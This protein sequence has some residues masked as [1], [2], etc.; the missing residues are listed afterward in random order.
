MVD[1][2]NEVTQN[3]IKSI[4][5]M[6]QINQIIK[7]KDIT[8]ASHYMVPSLKHEVPF[9]EI[10][11]SQQK[12]LVKSVIDSPVYNT[13][14]IY[15][16]REILKE[17]CQDNTINVDNLTIIDKLVLALA[18]R[19]RSIGNTVDIE[20][21]TKEKKSVTVSL[22]VSKVLEIALS[23]LQDIADKTLEDPYYKVVCSVPTIGVEYKLEKEL[24]NNVSSIQIENVQELR[25]TIGDAFIGELVKYV[26]AVYIKSTDDVL[27]PVDWAQF[28][29][30]NRIKVVETFKTGLLKEIMDYISSVRKEV[31]KIE[32]INLEFEGE[33]LE[34]RLSID[35]NFFTIS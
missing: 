31:D 32:L 21:Q 29:Y 8:Y 11:T 20:V 24:R 30:A 10:N 35:G 5:S 16:L 25:Q 1:T 14:F 12:R 15:T 28:S 33:K 18:L 4:T 23:T 2:N 22:D 17:N 13:E 3:T 27:I 34:R 6:D 7:R 9:N 26:S 19:I